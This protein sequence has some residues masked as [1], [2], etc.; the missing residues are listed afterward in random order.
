MLDK[1]KLAG[2]VTDELAAEYKKLEYHA[3]DCVQCGA[4]EKRCPFDV[5][6]RER[7]KEAAKVFGY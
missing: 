7:M 3:S 2:K 1:A 4:C 5:P 6:V